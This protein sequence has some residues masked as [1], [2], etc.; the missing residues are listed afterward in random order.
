MYYNTFRLI[1]IKPK[2]IHAQFPFRSLHYSRESFHLTRNKEISVEFTRHSTADVIGVFLVSVELN[3]V[4]DI[5]KT[6]GVVIR[7]RQDL[8]TVGGEVC[9]MN[10][11]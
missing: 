11:P 9:D 6:A 4:W 3:W 8:V 10:G 7:P 1:Q 2:G 5:P